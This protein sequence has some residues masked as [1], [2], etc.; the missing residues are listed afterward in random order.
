MNAGGNPIAAVA[1]IRFGLVASAA[2]AGR[3]SESQGHPPL[4]RTRNWLAAVLATSA[5]VESPHTKAPGG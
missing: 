2:G 3:R 5:L 4:A 1:P